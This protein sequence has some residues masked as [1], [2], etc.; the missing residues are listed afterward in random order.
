MEQSQINDNKDNVSKGDRSAR[1]DKLRFLF[2]RI[3]PN[4]YDFGAICNF[5]ILVF[6]L[7]YYEQS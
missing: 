3:E 7:E 2:C 5:Y 1:D 6:V 4:F